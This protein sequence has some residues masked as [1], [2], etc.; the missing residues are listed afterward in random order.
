MNPISSIGA[1][2][3]TAAMDRFSDSAKRTATGAGDLATEAVVQV[4]A[5]QAVSANVAVIK[6]GDEMFKRLLDIKV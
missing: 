2:G 4:S 1:A 6:A 5:R 3:L